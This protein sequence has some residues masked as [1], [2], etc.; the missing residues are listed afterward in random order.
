MVAADSVAPGDAAAAA[1]LPAS[2]TPDGTSQDPGRISTFITAP[3]PP[4][5]IPRCLAG[6][7][8]LAY[9]IVNKF[10]DH[11]PLYRQEEILQREGV[12]LSR[13]TL[14]DWLAG[15]ATVLQP[16]FAL[17]WQRVFASRELHTD[18]T[19]VSVQ[20]QKTKGRLWVYFGD[21]AHPYT[22]Y[23]FTLDRCAERPQKCLANFKGYLH[24]DAYSGYDQIFGA[25]RIEVACWAHARRYFHDAR[26]TD[27]VRATCVLA[28]I[29]RLYALEAAAKYAAGTLKLSLQDYWAVRLQLRERQATPILHSLAEYVEQQRHLVL[30]RSPI[31]EAFTYLHN[32]WEALSRY[33]G[34]GFLD[35]DN[36]V[37]EQALRAIA[38][39]R[40]NWLFVGSA[41]GG[42]TAATL[43]SFVQTCKR[44]GVDAWLYLR[45]VLR[46]LPGVAESARAVELP[47]LL[48]D[49]WAARERA[50]V[51]SAVPP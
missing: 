24:A 8:L 43:Y 12:W 48:P 5:P 14:C 41:E 1:A 13:R 11:L 38:V 19:P 45:E 20:G 26:G 27:P 39:G 46:I 17:M 31:G 51:E 40:K 2:R 4:Q 44:L 9:I 22:V 6:P 33:T 25:D 16:L 37:A 36:N 18:D 21:W 28:S 30:P 34:H 15:C 35:I 29:G 32:Q 7:G 23:D 10:A 3:M 42:R 47:K 50:A 49:V